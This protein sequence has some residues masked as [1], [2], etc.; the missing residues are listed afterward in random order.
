MAHKKKKETLPAISDSIDFGR[1]HR[2]L[3]VFQ[4]NSWR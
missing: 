4:T 2:Q 1:K 3:L